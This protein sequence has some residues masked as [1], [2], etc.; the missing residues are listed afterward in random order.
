VANL[1]FKLIQGEVGFFLSAAPRFISAPLQIHRAKPGRSFLVNR[2]SRESLTGK[3]V[4]Q[5][6]D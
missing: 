5:F 4:V 2:T 3:N 1:F 6:A